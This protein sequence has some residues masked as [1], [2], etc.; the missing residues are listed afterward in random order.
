MLL[1]EF[2]PDDKERSYN[3]SD[4]QGKRKQGASRKTSHDITDKADRSDRQRVWQLRVYVI[5]VVTL[6]TGTCHNCR[7]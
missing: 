6:R 7:I 1:G 2:F 3:K 4:T 5:N